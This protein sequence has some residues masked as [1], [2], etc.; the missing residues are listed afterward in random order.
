M[1]DLFQEKGFTM[2][3]LSVVTSCFALSSLTLS[4]T[5]LCPRLPAADWPQWRGPN[6]D[7][8]A[9]DFTPPKTWPKELTQKWKIAVGEG[10]ATPALVGDKLYVFSRQDGNEI[11]RCLDAGT[12]KEIWQDKY[13]SAGATGPAQQY[14]GPRCSPAV[15]DG[16]VITFGVRGVISCLDAAKGTKLWRKDDFPNSYPRFFPSSSPMMVNGMCIAQVGGQGNGGIWAYDLATGDVKWK[17]TGDSPAYASPDLMSIGGAKLVVAMTERKIV[18]L[19]AA[20][21]KLVWETPFVVQGMMGYNAASPMVDGQTMI[22]TGSGRG[23]HAVQLAKDGDNF[24]AKELWSNPDKSVQ[25]S[26][27]VIKEGLLYGL[28]QANELF[29]LNTQDGKIAWTASLTAGSG[30]APAAGGSSS[31]RGG[32]DGKAGPASEMGRPGGGP[33]TNGPGGGPGM[34]GP[35]GRRGGPGGGRGMGGRG[36]G[37]GSIVNAGQVLMALTPASELVVF[38]PDGKAYTELARVKVAQSQTYAY[39]VVSANRIYVK[40]SDNVTLWTAD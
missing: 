32:S 26:T 24:T 35:G 12:G 3:R 39:P 21:G 14:S 17:W 4:L 28:T 23:V 25:F 22:Y 19:N 8:K 9:A 33:G 6:R 13:E 2:K 15:A 18:A 11:T 1:H 20:D 29:C 31:E 37:Y 30:G 27:P 5:V 10:V 7:A 38:K 34:G 36:G 16:K 40:D